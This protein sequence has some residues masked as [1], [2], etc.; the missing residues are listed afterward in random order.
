MSSN[1]WSPGRHS[2]PFQNVLLKISFLDL[3]DDSSCLPFRQRCPCVWCWKYSLVCALSKQ[4]DDAA[5][6]GRAPVRFAYL[7][8]RAFRHGDIVRFRLQQTFYYAP[9][10]RYRKTPCPIWLKRPV[11]LLSALLLGKGDQS[12]VGWI[13]NAYTLG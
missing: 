5:F 10:S 3:I 4:G 7:E 11:D 8:G 13:S 6:I 12:L 9:N 1:P 2:N